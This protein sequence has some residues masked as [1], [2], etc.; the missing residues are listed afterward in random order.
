MT[1]SV[2]LVPLKCL[3][4]GIYVPAEEDEVAWV[5]QQ[6]G[7]GMQ[8][9]ATGLAALTVNWAAAREQAEAIQW[10][11]F[12]VFTG[13]VNMLRRETYS[14]GVLSALSNLIDSPEKL[15]S[16]SRRLYVPAFP[17]SLEQIETL[18]ADL[19]RKQVALTPGPAAGAVSD[20]TLFPDD[21]R[22]AVEFVVLTIEA[23]RKDKLREVDFKLD[24]GEPELWILPFEREKL[25]LTI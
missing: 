23:D 16:A 17:A 3:R 15:W 7:Q 14:G 25:A 20:C 12:W 10:R 18:G 9:T 5:C 1:T 4:C 6:C 11:P 8:L 24:L 19:T 21:A 2:E 13:T 22:Q